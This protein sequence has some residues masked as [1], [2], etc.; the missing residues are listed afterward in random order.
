[1]GQAPQGCFITGAAA[2]AVGKVRRG[3]RRPAGL[4]LDGC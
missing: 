4:S 1:M 2:H 3:R